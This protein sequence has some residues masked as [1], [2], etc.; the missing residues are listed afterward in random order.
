MLDTGFRR[1]DVVDYLSEYLP[2][3]P[4]SEPISN[5]DG[6]AIHGERHAHQHHARGGGVQMKGFLRP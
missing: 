6:H 5:P 1:D 4:L 2:F 3:Y